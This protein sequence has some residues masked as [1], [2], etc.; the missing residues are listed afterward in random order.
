MAVAEAEPT[1]PAKAK[2]AGKKKAKAATRVV[3]ES[4]HEVSSLEA[5]GFVFETLA[6][7][8]SIL[9]LLTQRINTARY[10]PLSHSDLEFKVE[11]TDKSNLLGNEIGDDSTNAKPEPKAKPKSTT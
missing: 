7:D 8:D 5:Y 4:R 6:D 2:V 11:F 10:R 3:F 1:G 9:K